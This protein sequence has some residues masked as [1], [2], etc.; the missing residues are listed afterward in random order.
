M[1]YNLSE[2][3]ETATSVSFK[4]AKFL[5]NKV[6]NSFLSEPALKLF[7]NQKRNKHVE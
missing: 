4:L 5:R 6:K 1:E 3:R 2:L 7:K